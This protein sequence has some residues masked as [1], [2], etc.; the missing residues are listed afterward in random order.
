MPFTGPSTLPLLSGPACSVPVLSLCLSYPVLLTQ[1]A[2]GRFH[3]QVTLATQNGVPPTCVQRVFLFTS[4]HSFER[5]RMY[6]Q[7]IALRPFRAQ[8]ARGFPVADRVTDSLSLTHFCSGS[9]ISMTARVCTRILSGSSQCSMNV[10]AAL[11]L[12][13]SVFDRI[14]PSLIARCP[15]C[16][17]CPSCVCPANNCALTCAGAAQ[18]VTE[19]GA[20][21]LLFVVGVFVGAFLVSG[22]RGRCWATLL[23]WPTVTPS[24]FVAEPVRSST[25]PPTT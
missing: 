7:G 13:S 16:P 18:S 19:S 24:S 25:L 20:G 17:A 11:G 9:T 22:L 15:A 6:S 5:S 14:I 1:K 2:Q 21:W 10:P 12:A 23:R 8:R 4:L 3:G